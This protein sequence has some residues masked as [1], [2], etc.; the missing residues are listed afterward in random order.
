MNIKEAKEQIEYAIKSYLL[1]DEW[2]DYQIS[3]EKQRPVFLMGPPGIGKTAIMDQIA[4]D[5]QINLVS[6]A[7]TH[8]TRESAIGQPMIVNKNFIG[9]EVKVSESTMSEVIANIYET[10]EETGIHEGDKIRIKLLEVDEK[11]GKFRLSARAL[12]DKP[13]GYVEAERPSRANRGNG[14]RP[15]RRAPRNDF[16]DKGS[17]F[18]GDGARL[19]RRH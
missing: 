11:T 14:Q 5:L 7:M 19:D 3:L 13:E 15:E 12:K 8:Q 18:L 10:M 2:G 16:R 17:D 4:Q 9:R 1:T 6:Y